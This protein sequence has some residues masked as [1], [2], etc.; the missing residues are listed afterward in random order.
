MSD[1]DILN[2]WQINA[3]P[4]TTA[5]RQQQIESRRLVT[6]QAIVDTVTSLP[7]KSVLDVGCGEGWLVRALADSGR[8]ASGID[9]IPALV[10]K[11]R[12]LGGGSFF[13]LAYE[14][15]SGQALPNRYDIAVCNFSL[16]GQQSV[17][18]VFRVMPEILV[19][20]NGH[21]VVQTLH[22]V[23]SCGDL[24]YVDGWREGSWN[25]F[26][27]EF[28]APAPWYFRTI[29]SWLQ[30]FRDNG[31]NLLQVAEPIRPDTGSPVSLILVGQSPFT[32]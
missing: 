20:A 25:G 10:E 13:D 5:V 24:P 26:G 1:C 16:L 21:F 19:A 32:A 15:L 3:A 2:S 17:D 12:E 6:D 28:K 8:S 31:F 27:P 9:A 23:V 7:G 11:A 4:W 18:H 30:L 14:D 29:A 22:P